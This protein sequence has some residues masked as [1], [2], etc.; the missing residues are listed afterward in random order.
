M[1]DWHSHILPGIDDGSQHLADSL[2]MME[3]MADQGVTTVIAT[4][5][6]CANRESVEEFLRRRQEARQRLEAQLPDGAPRLLCGA[7][8]EFYSGISRLPDLKQL[9]IEGTHVLLLEMSISRWTEYTVKELVE[10]A[11]RGNLTLVLAHVERYLDLQTEEVRERLYKSGILMQSN[12]S[13]FLRLASRRKALAMLRSGDIHLIGSDCH[14]TDSRSPNVGKA[15]EYIEK[16]LGPQAVAR[17]RQRGE[18]LL[19]TKKEN[20]V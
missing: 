7:E 18:H 6:F 5:H 8:V 1:I 16:K 3:Q 12:A 9:C 4:P 10:L 20:L 19:K 15:M 2:T 11:G 14:N 13:C 17:L